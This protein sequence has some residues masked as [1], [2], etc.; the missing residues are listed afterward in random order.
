MAGGQLKDR[1][2][3][4][5]QAVAQVLVVCSLGVWLAKRHGFDRRAIAAVSGV[6]WHVLIP[7]LM[8]SSIVGAVTPARLVLLWP[9]L[10]VS[11]L[12]IVLGAA[13][14]LALGWAA[15]L[16]RDMWFFAVMA[17]S[18]PNCGNLPWLF[19]PSI[20]RYYAP[21]G[22][23][24]GQVQYMVGLVSS[25]GGGDDD[26]DDTRH[27]GD[28][29][30]LADATRGAKA[31]QPPPAPGPPAPPDGLVA[32]LPHSNSCASLEFEDDDLAAAAAAREA[33][34]AAAAP[35][36]ALRHTALAPAD[37][38]ASHR[39]A[40]RLLGLGRSFRSSFSRSF[41]RGLRRSNSLVALAWTFP[42]GWQAQRGPSPAAAPGSAWRCLGGRG[43]PAPRWLAAP[44]RW[45]RAALAHPAVNLPLGATVAGLAVAA[46]G[47]VRR[48][49]VDEL[50]PLH[51]LWVSL[52]W[53]GAA[54]AP[55]ATMQIGAELMQ[56]APVEHSM[57]VSRRHQ[58]SATAI[59]IAVKLVLV[60][61]L[62]VAVVRAAGLHRLVPGDDTV[63]QLLLLVESAVPAAVT[64][65]VVCG[66]VYPDIR[67]LSRILFWQYVASLITLPAFL[68]LAAG[69]RTHPLR[70][71]TA[72]SGTAA[73]MG[74]AAQRAL[75]L[76]CLAAL[77][78]SVPASA[79]GPPPKRHPCRC[80][81]R[82]TCTVQPGGFA[83]TG[84]TPSVAA[85][86]ACAG[87]P[88]VPN[89]V[90]VC[91]T[92]RCAFV[93][94]KGFTR[95]RSTCCPPKNIVP[96]P[97]NYSFWV[98]GVNALA[99]FNGKA[100]SQRFPQTII[101]SIA[102]VNETWAA[103]VGGNNYFMFDGKFWYEFQDTNG[104]YGAA[105]G[106]ENLWLVGGQA[107]VWLIYANYTLRWGEVPGTTSALLHVTPLVDK[108]AIAVGEGGTI[109]R[110]KGIDASRW[111]LEDSGVTAT[112]R[113]SAAV[114][115]VPAWIVGDGGTILR[116][117]DGRWVK[118]ESGTTA[119]LMSVTALS[120]SLALAVGDGG[121]ILQWDGTS[122]KQAAPGDGWRD[123]VLTGVVLAGPAQAYAVGHS[124]LLMSWDGSSWSV[125]SSGGIGSYQCIATLPPAAAGGP[126]RMGVRGRRLQQ[127]GSLVPIASTYLPPD[128][129]CV[130]A[131]RTVPLTSVAASLLRLPSV[132]LP[133][134][135]TGAS[136]CAVT[137]TTF[138]STGGLGV[139]CS[140]AST[141]GVL[142]TADGSLSFMAYASS[143]TGGVTK[144]AAGTPF[145]VDKSWF[146]PCVTA[147]QPQWP[148][149]PPPASSCGQGAPV[150]DN[151]GV[152]P[153]LWQQ[154][155]SCSA[156]AAALTA[157]GGFDRV[158]APANTP[159]D[160][161]QLLFGLLSYMS[162]LTAPGESGVTDVGLS[163]WPYGPCLAQAGVLGWKR[164]TAQLPQGVTGLSAATSASIWWTKSDVFIGFRGT[165]DAGDATL[166]LHSG[167]VSA[168]RAVEP[169]IAG[170]L[171]ELKPALDAD[172]K[173]WF[174]GHSLGG[175][176]ATLGAVFVP[177][178][179]DGAGRA[180]YAARVGGVVTFAQPRVGSD[181]FAAW[182][183]APDVLGSKHVRVL[184][185]RDPV[186]WTPVGAGSLTYK[187]VGSA[188]Q[189][190]GA[191]GG[192]LVGA[193][194]FTGDQPSQ[195][196]S[197]GIDA[198]HHPMSAVFDAMIALR[199]QSALSP[200]GACFIR[201]LSTCGASSMVCDGI[202][203][204]KHVLNRACQPCTS[205]ESCRAPAGW[206]MS[207]SATCPRANRLPLG[208]K[209]WTCSWGPGGAGD[210]CIEDSSCLSGSCRGY[211]VDANGVMVGRCARGSKDAA[212]RTDGE[213]LSGRC[214]DGLP[215]LG[216][217]CASFGLSC[218]SCGA[219]LPG[220]A[221]RGDRDCITGSC[222]S[223]KPDE[224]GDS[225]GVC[226]RGF[227]N[228]GCSADGDCYSGRCQLDAIP[229]TNSF[230]QLSGASS[231]CR[232]CGI[233]RP[234]ARCQTSAQCASN[235]C[236]NILPDAATG[237]SLGTC[238]AVPRDATCVEDADCYSGA[239]RRPARRAPA[240]LAPHGL[241]ARCGGRGEARSAGRRAH[242]GW[243]A[244]A[245]GFCTSSVTGSKTCG[246]SS[247][248]GGCVS[249]KDC[250]SDDCIAPSL[251]PNT[252]AAAKNK[253]MLPGQTG[254]CNKGATKGCRTNDDC[255][256][257]ACGCGVTGFFFNSCF[258][259]CSAPKTGTDGCFGLPN[260]YTGGTW[261]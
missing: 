191:E 86:C 148:G 259:S 135:P 246:P 221:C 205:D 228:M 127:V 56:G 22:D 39:S 35:P 124:S 175:A 75:A 6:N 257:N 49:M 156:A 93:C 171:A 11:L 84:V 128:A 25:S 48:L 203:R 104:L 58:W 243:R 92:D 66:R 218:K 119:N 21:P 238:T 98:G 108:A 192:Q 88:A 60:P 102:I 237:L 79:S 154:A 26:D 118:T 184:Y 179:V 15:A 180:A 251:I 235:S 211:T 253:T 107:T 67:P 199:Q 74:A 153:K 202:V 10:L 209:A 132:T 41:S 231:G 62:N 181:E 149:A 137:P 8:F 71:R 212:C 16:P 145:T 7:A 103:A 65:L 30:V 147:D 115:G 196:S 219:G 240:R 144:T 226:G 198:G 109:A 134:C 43:R 164:V 90:S 157:A 47:P 141:C 159:G 170:V 64:L 45:C 19:M 222:L 161:R 146:F 123:A 162:Y 210:A 34:G 44:L 245:A 183:D 9:M 126:P 70:S 204:C 189:M 53:V 242:G 136:A 12:H 220:T 73:T 130:T 125:L 63:Y 142:P 178:A 229:K 122:W 133:V 87:C 177:P 78:A 215:F 111:Y 100:W 1:I 217:A 14:A 18:L 254:W 176:L 190:C 51:W 37:S 230:C 114:R 216:G 23:A 4:A 249:N 81:G 223:M 248:F 155:G 214:T 239:P 247:V 213:C 54:A 24:A 195:C 36:D 260:R 69:G 82:D 89:A 234:G 28:V 129:G 208:T 95:C 52:V 152:H 168:F 150:G 57:A 140:G 94:Q 40:S 182:Y 188:L 200:F 252:F 32:V 42:L 139:S 206:A 173:L 99:G 72:P 197:S 31:Q 105:T 244:P 233:G 224:N 158:S 165:D 258:R 151:L 91:N 261:G 172:F 160:D 250:L 2:N 3:V 193:K 232:S 113:S 241:G 77:A 61:L 207:R 120:D 83:A 68:A 29:A 143:G 85:R 225:V 110:V 256:S 174:T 76:L 236:L 96:M 185:W 38:F 5:L 27:G 106:E 117:L 13:P 167:F 255:C 80:T 17:S 166:K 59:A 186:P 163:A 116:W 169:L 201:F 97:G 194:S 121:T 227:P 33:F 138:A 112:L 131:T 101:S 46:V 55:L 20:I 50:A 187:H